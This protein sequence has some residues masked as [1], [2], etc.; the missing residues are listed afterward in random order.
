MSDRWAFRGVYT[1]QARKFLR[2]KCP[3]CGDI[4][5]DEPMVTIP[6]YIYEALM[7]AAERGLSPD[8][9]HRVLDGGYCP[10]CQ[11]Q[12]L[13]SWLTRPPKPPKPPKDG[14]WDGS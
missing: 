2:P 8:G 11:G 13:R 6:R 3:R 5:S 9:K 10:D 14:Q 4:A 1:R 12:C 7:A